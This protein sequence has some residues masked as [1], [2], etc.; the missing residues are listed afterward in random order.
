[1]RDKTKM[2]LLNMRSGETETEMRLDCKL[3]QDRDYLLIF[4][5]KETETE[6]GSEFHTRP[7]RDRESHILQS[8]D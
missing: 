4:K 8:Q 7:R 5:E 3:F 1:M 2:R 6:H